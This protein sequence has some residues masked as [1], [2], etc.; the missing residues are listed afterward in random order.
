MVLLLL[1]VRRMGNTASLPVATTLLAET[2]LLFLHTISQ[3]L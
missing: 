1:V 3:I 2:E